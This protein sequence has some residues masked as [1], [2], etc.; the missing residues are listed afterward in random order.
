MMVEQFIR[1]K[2]V[3]RLTGLP[4]STIY[5]KMAKGL[6]PKNHKNLASARCVA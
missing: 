2:E 1:K 6:F 3:S 5:D 4:I